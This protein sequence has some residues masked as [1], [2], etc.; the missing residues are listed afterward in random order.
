MGRSLS[1]QFFWKCSEKSYL[2]DGTIDFNEF[3]SMMARKMSG[4]F[5]E[6]LKTSFKV[7]DKNS[8]GYIERDELEQMMIRLGE[9]LTE[10]EID[11]MI[12]EAD[13]D[14]DGRVNFKEFLAMMKSD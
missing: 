4:N 6:E 5:E 14:K 12:K 10:K 3:L 9:N 7:F 11:A 2:D 13:S 1:Y 8:N